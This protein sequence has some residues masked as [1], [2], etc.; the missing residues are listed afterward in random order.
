MNGGGAAGEAWGGPSLRLEALELI[1]VAL[2]LVRPFRTSFGEERVKR[3]LL[4]RARTDGPD[5]WGEC[6]AAPEPRYSEEWLEGAWFAIREW[7]GPAVL[8]GGPVDDPAQVEKRWSWVRG[9]RMAKAA[10]EAAVVDAWLRAAG[11]SLREF[12]GGVQDRVPCGVSVG[13]SHPVEATLEEIE[14]YVAE[15]YQRVKVKIEPGHDVELVRAVRE[16]FPNIDLSVDANGAYR[17][18]DTRV[19]VAL[20]EFDLLMVQQPFHPEDFVGH[21]RLQREIRTAVCLDESIR[22]ARDVDT[23]IALRACMVF[24]LKPGRVGGLQ[25]SLRV[26]DR[27]QAS[28]RLL[29]VGGMRETGVG[30]ALNLAVASLPAVGLP[31]GTSGS[32]R[33]FEEDLTRPF[34]LEPDGTMEVPRGPG[35]GVTPLPDR[36]AACTARTETVRAG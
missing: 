8:A 21:A 9:H 35:I 7:I 14:G 34:V 28:S 15:G 27:V 18:A 24:N 6:V 33:C 13:I 12:L 20:D 22:S 1:E 10:V 30:R 32:H 5:G 3:A 19:F 26:H 23:A 2:P 29:R 25:E 17:L 4:V 11:R 36:L 16:A 31:G